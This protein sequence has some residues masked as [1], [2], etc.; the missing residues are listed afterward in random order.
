VLSRQVLAQGVE[1]REAVEH[2][3]RV[4]SV[5]DVNVYVSEP[6]EEDWRPLTLSKQKALWSFRNR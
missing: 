2:L 3:R 4:R 1:A 5:V 6:D